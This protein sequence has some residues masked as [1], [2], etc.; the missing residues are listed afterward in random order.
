MKQPD[1]GIVSTLYERAVAT[2]DLRRSAGEANAEA[3]LRS[4]W[5]G[6]V[7]FLVRI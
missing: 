2:A 1:L 4:F 5:T 7:D 6:Y 3:A